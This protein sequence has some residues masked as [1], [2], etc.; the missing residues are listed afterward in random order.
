[1]GDPGTKNW[2]SVFTTQ[3]VHG[4]FLVASDTSDNVNSEI[5]TLGSILGSSISEIYRLQASVRPGDQAGHE[6][7]PF[8]FFLFYIA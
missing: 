8:F 1:M 4:V 7:T 5:Q 3:N 6:R 2:V